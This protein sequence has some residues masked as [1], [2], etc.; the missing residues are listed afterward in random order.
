[1]STSRK[2]N[3]GRQATSQLKMAETFRIAPRKLSALQG[4]GEIL[5]YCTFIETHGY[6]KHHSNRTI[7][8]SGAT[9]E[10]RKAAL[11]SVARQTNILNPN[12]VKEYLQA[13]NLE[14]SRKNKLIDDL[15]GFYQYK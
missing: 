2:P 14:N 15:T 12:Q 7:R 4:F 11:L 1:M 9:I 3:T 5:A 10:S 13:A 8:Y 6:K